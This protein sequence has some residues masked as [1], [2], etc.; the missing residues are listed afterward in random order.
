M[1]IT[2]GIDGS[3]K[4]TII[5][6]ICLMTGR[7]IKHAGGPPV[8]ATN[9]LKRLDQYRVLPEAVLC[10]RHPLISELIYGRIL[11]GHTVIGEDILWKC[12]ITCIVR[13]NPI[14]LWCEPSKD[15]DILL[16]D[17]VHKS[18][19]HLVEV[20]ASRH[21]I[22]EQYKKMGLAL[23]DMGAKVIVYDRFSD[24]MHETIAKVLKAEQHLLITRRHV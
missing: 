22:A 17:K 18:E 16:Q 20:F 15:T 6:E 11:R 10:D 14:F 9:Y 4:S 23:K 12:I 19:K 3:G 7:S 1:I 13:N 24:N 5:S 21:R 8:D 2:E